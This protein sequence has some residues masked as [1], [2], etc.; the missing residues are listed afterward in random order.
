MSR[1]APSYTL[2]LDCPAAAAPAASAYT[3][4]FRAACVILG[5]VDALVKHLLA[6]EASV[7]AWLSGE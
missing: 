2:T 5:G 7:R 4:T 6:P 3:R 1:R